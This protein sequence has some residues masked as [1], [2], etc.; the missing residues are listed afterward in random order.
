MGM[1]NLASIASALLGGGLSPATPAAVIQNGT[2]PSQRSVVSTLAELT[3]A[4]S[5][6]GLGSPAIVVIGPVAALAAT[7]PSL[8]AWRQVA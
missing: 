4:V 5:A 1:A 7:A 3:G 2:L 8:E 6:A